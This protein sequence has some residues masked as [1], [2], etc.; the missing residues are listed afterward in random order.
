[1]YNVVVNGEACPKNVGYD[2]LVSFLGSC[3][4]KENSLQF[5]LTL[6]GLPFEAN[7]VSFEIN[8]HQSGN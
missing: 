7:G 1:M 6:S 3:G 2:E 8:K 4:I 5:T